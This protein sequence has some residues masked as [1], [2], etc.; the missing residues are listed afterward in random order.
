MKNVKL[1]LLTVATIFSFA[2]NQSCKKDS[3]SSTPTNDTIIVDDAASLAANLNI[4]GGVRKPGNI[5]APAGSAAFGIDFNILTPN[6]IL[7]PGNTF[8]FEIE[9]N[10]TA[11]IL[12]IQLDGASEYL[13][14][15]VDANGN[16]LAKTT[17]GTQKFRQC[18]S[19]DGCISI[20]Q[21]KPMV[22]NNMDIGATVQVYQPPLQGTAPDLS[23]LNNRQY[24][25]PPK[26]IRYKTFNTGVGDIFA[27]L[28]WNK[29]ADID[30]WMI[31]PNGNKIY[32]A[33]QISST[34]GELDYDNT[35]AYGPENIFYKSTPPSG[36]YEVWVHYYSGNNGPVDWVVNLKN[37]P[38]YNTY[39]G[40]LGNSDEK[41]LV[42]TFTK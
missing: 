8:D 14:A 33:D 40:T 13:M 29:E 31:E 5:P 34:G 18:C 7:T 20:G 35:E 21:G 10:A 15:T 9:S 41:T 25:S 2:I 28:T 27:T 12:Y 32:Y 4:E 36:K 1:L 39:R 19:P 38:A 30:L 26:R 6:V 42:A 17:S 24:W 23:F 11:K 22:M 3:N 16:I 37:G